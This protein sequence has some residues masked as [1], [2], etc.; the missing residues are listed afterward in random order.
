MGR[1]K[2][3]SGMLLMGG[4]LLVLLCLLT[5]QAAAVDIVAS[6]SCGGEGDGTNLTWT[7]DSEGTLTISGTGK[8]ADYSYSS[9]PW[10]SYE[11]SLKKLVIGNGMTSI[12]SYAFRGCSGFTGSL[13]IPNSVTTIGY[14]AF[15]GCSGFTGS[16]TIPDSVTKIGHMAFGHMKSIISIEVAAGNPSYASANGMLLMYPIK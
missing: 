1:T 6:G 8:M 2:R 15:Y 3:L 5:V 12:G 13:T 11:A 7:L 9:A 10:H 14:W 4:C 16:L